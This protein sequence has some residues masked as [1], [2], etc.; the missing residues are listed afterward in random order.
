MAHNRA[1]GV[2]R[3]MEFVQ[4]HPTAL[5]H[6]WAINPFSSLPKPFGVAEVLLN[7][8]LRAGT[9]NNDLNPIKSAGMVSPLPLCL[10]FDLCPGLVRA[11][12]DAQGDG[13]KSLLALASEEG[14]GGDFETGKPSRYSPIK[15][16]S[17]RLDRLV[18]SFSVTPVF[19]PQT[20]GVFALVPHRRM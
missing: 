20:T 2:I 1:R 5:Y 3:D 18:V 10:A 14:N 4:F 16:A 8:V 15:V 12:T 6:P 11:G 19:N 17:A 7:S 13:L 9:S